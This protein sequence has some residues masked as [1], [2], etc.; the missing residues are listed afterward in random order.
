MDTKSVHKILYKQHYLDTIIH[1]IELQK[2]SFLSLVDD[3]KLEAVKEEIDPKYRIEDFKNATVAKTLYL[4][5]QLQSEILILENIALN[6]WFGMTGTDSTESEYYFPMV[7]VPRTMVRQGETFE[8]EIYLSVYYKTRKIQQIRVNGKR[9][10]VKDGKS[11][12]RMKTNTLGKHQYHVSISEKSPVT[13]QID[14]Y[15]RTF[16][17]EVIE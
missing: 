3:D 13:G 6:H 15:K 10:S 14:T 8:A 16:E 11:I 5:E 4:L 12:V 17:Y 9:L 7:N 1:H 2:T